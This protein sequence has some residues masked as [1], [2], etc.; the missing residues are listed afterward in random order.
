M[1]TTKRR[2]AILATVASASFG[3]TAQADGVAHGR[4]VAPA[5]IEGTWVMAIQP[6]FCTTTPAG[7]AGDPVPGTAPVSGYLTFHRGGTMTESNSNAAFEPGQ[8]GPGHGSWER[9][10]QTSYQFMFQGFV[11]FDSTQPPFRYK[12]GYQ[13]IEQTLE[14]H[15]NDEFTTSGTVRFF[16]GTS[17]TNPYIVGCA[18]SS[19]VRLY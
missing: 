4:S 14:M 17:T 18:R 19:G 15:T 3:L 13:R 11:T 7:N 8:R 5:P 10:G 9:T 2:S 16:S 6:V 1:H 12:R